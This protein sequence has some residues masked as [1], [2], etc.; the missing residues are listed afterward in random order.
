MKKIDI[1]G[2][3]PNEVHESVLFALEQINSGKKIRLKSFKISAVSA[4]AAAVISVTAISAAAV[5][6]YFARNGSVENGRLIYSF[7]INYELQPGVFEVTPG[8]IPERFA[9]DGFGKYYPVDNYGHGITLFPVYNTNNLEELESFKNSRIEVE[10]VEKSILSGMEADII[11]YRNAD[12][13]LCGRDILL[14][15]PEEGFVI[16]IYGDHNIDTDTL[17][18]FADNLTV[19]RVGEENFPTDEEKSK[20][21]NEERQQIQ[22]DVAEYEAYLKLLRNGLPRDKFISPGN[23]V[24]TDRMGYTVNEWEFF[25]SCAGLDRDNFYPYYDISEWLNSDGT[26]KSYTREHYIYETDHLNS[27][28]TLKKEI[29]E[30][31]L[32][33]EDF[34]PGFTVEEEAAEQVFLRVNITAKCYEEAAENV[35]LDADI[36]YY[37]ILENGN[38]TYSGEEYRPLPSQGCNWHRTGGAV[39]IS[40]PNNT[41]DAGQFF[42]KKM[43]PGESITYDLVFIVDKDRTE[44]ISLD[45]NGVNYLGDLSDGIEGVNGYLILE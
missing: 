5:G 22:N 27:D 45:F 42:W 16:R 18:K 35:P 25:K 40:C 29:R 20:I 17:L 3:V 8:Y 28:G 14:F 23:E 26:L 15:S 37:N 33:G 9:S 41:D 36:S 39:W 31:L 44:N 24:R 6:L 13:Y 2:N 19:K 32:S 7:D 12:K 21:E 1:Y 30:M 4:V 38:Y 34:T 10:N 43:T 11:T